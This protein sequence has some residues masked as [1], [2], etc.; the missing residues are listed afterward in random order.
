MQRMRDY[1]SPEEYAETQRANAIIDACYG[2]G[3][4]QRADGY[5]N[6]LTK[7]GTKADS[8]TAFRFIAEVSAG[9]STF[10]AFF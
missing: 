5:Q 1:I 7:Y 4:V 8:S 2:T 10:A 3:Q 6:M 9:V